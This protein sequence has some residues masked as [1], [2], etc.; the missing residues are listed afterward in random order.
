MSKWK[1]FSGLLCLSLVT[2]SAFAADIANYGDEEVVVY[3]DEVTDNHVDTVIDLKDYKG[4][5]KSVPELL[6]GTAGIQIQERPVGGAED[7]SVKLRGHDSRRFLVLVDGVP[8]KNSGVMGGSY[9]SWDAMPMDMIEKIEIIKGAKSFKYG[10]TDGGV[11][12]IITKHT[13][14]GQIKFSVGS[15]RLR[16]T[17]IYYKGSAGQLDYGINYLFE[18][19]DGYLR[20]ADY[21]NKLFGL[22]LAYHLSKTDSIK[23]NF[24]HNRTHIGRVVQN[25]P[26]TAGYNSYYPT[27]ILGDAYGNDQAFG[28]LPGDGSR[29]VTTGNRFDISYE[30]KRDSGSDLLTYWKNNEDLHELKVVNGA[31]AYDRH[32]SSDK[33]FGY[34]YRGTQVLNDKHELAFGGEYTRLRYGYGWYNGVKPVTASELYPSQKADVWGLYVGDTWT[35][36]KRWTLDYGLRYD[37]MSADRDDPRGTKVKAYDDRG[38]SPKLTATLKHDD[39]TT[40]S[41]SINRI[42]RSP[43]MAEFYWYYQDLAG[44]NK[45]GELAP[46]KGWGYDLSIAH[47]FS[48]KY[49][50]K[51]TLF[52][53]NFSSFINFLHTRP[54]NVYMLNGVKIWGFEWENNYKFDDYSSVYLNYTNQHTFK[55][56]AKNFDHAGLPDQ[57]DYRPRHMLSLGYKF[58]R[59]SWTLQYDMHYIG[60]QRAMYGYPA[61]LPTETN[62]AELGGYVVHN[63]SITKEFNKQTSAN[64]TVYNLFDKKYSEIFGYPMDGRTYVLSCSYNF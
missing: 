30:S 58:H 25:I 49:D 64:F 50:S 33:S 10:Q 4:E 59:D 63:L 37:V 20:N 6:R 52:Y 27:T 41:L 53:Q 13:N 62:I 7:Q 15:N 26:G 16:Q 5:V 14:G 22:N 39:K 45:K 8:Q 54:F 38:L 46:E 61:A 51:V 34:I 23:V 35:M 17:S 40:T 48:D 3:G 31:V 56:G 43:S 29:T 1:I 47:K 11:I 2:G 18:S 19:N 12:N 44:N 36:D 28:T 42:W 57:L 32:N 60:N 9:F 21:G 24:L 55:D